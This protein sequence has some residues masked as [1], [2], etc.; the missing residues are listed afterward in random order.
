MMIFWGSGSGR[1]SYESGCHEGDLGSCLGL[2][3]GCSFGVGGGLGLKGIFG[4][5][6][7]MFVTIFHVFRHTSRLSRI[8]CL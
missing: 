1:L 6:I 2:C 5:G 3:V 8:S 4:F 7:L